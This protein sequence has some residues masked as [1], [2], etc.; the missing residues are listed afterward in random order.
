M[1]L[2]YATIEIANRYDQYR[3]EDG[4]ISKGEI[5]RWSGEMLVDTGAIRM[6]INEEIKK[7]LGLKDGF[8]TP[9]T[10][11]DGSSK[12]IELVGDLEVRFGNRSCYTDAFVLPGNTEPLLG[13]IPIEGMDLAVIPSENKLDYNP[14][15]PDGALFSL[16]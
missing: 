2:T 8:K 16:K 9:V 1:G 3:F 11:A 7:Q 13:A 15:H 4:L 10:L 5:R 14:K 12:I 6:A